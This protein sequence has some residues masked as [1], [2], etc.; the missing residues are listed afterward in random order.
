MLEQS[1]LQRHHLDDFIACC[2]PGEYRGDRE[3]V[4]NAAGR[5]RSPDPCACGVRARRPWRLLL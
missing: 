3:P 2:K 5:P 1:R 4:R